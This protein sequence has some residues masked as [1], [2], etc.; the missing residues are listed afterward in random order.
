MND[1]SLRRYVLASLTLTLAPTGCATLLGLD[2]F[3]EGP[4][5]GG[6]GGSGGMSSSS[7][8]TGGEAISSSASSGGSCVSGTTMPCYSGPAGTEGVAKCK[9]GTVTCQMNGTYGVCA[10]QVLPATENCQAKGD[11]DCN[12][13][14]CADAI[15]SNI[16]ATAGEQ[17]ATSIAVDTSGNVLLAGFF[18]GSL[19][20]GSTTLIAATPDYFLVKLDPGGNPLWAKQFGDGTDN[21]SRITVT[22]DKSGNVFIAGDVSGNVNFGTGALAGSANEDV[23]LASFDPAGTP[24]WAKRFGDTTTQRANSV[25]TDSLGNVII[26]GAFQGTINFGA[27]PMTATQ[28]DGFLVEFAPDGTHKWTK[29]FGEQAGQAASYQ[30]VGDIALD[31]ADNI[32]ATGLFANSIDFNG[33]TLMTA[34]ASKQFIASFD[35]TGG[36]SWSKQLPPPSGGM[37]R[38][39]A[40]TAGNIVIAGDFT[41]NINLGGGNLTSSSPDIYLAKFNV[42]GIP[43]WSEHVG[44]PGSDQVMS[45]AVDKSGNILLAG[46]SFGNIDFGNGVL[47]NG[48]GGQSDFIIAKFPPAGGTSTWSK[49]LGDVGQQ[50]AVGIAADPMS[51]AV[52][53][54]GMTT[55]TVDFGLGP[56]TSMGS[57]DVVLA[58]FQP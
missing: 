35:S 41:G 9:G 19:S 42:F 15:W 30:E 27:G 55:K 13:T 5:S 45:I 6:A 12:G 33:A 39:I 11:E 21:G 10:G 37:S 48:G 56:L 17:N 46:L 54:T 36:P 28:F 50:D 51:G 20:F 53:F 24:I 49:L 4:G 38:L 57:Y 25:R 14:G 18:T 29:R 1:R 7:S 26:S 43:L 8:G 34:N 40:D 2:D 47:T 58:K 3:K 16:Y 32:L 23:F 22:T 52:L 44:G 31:T